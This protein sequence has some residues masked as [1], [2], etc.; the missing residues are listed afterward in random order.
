VNTDQDAPS[1]WYC[2]WHKV[3]ALNL[4]GD[5]QWFIAK[6]K[7]PAKPIPPSVVDKGCDYYEKKQHRA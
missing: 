2:T 6:G 5:C 3:V 7:G 1:C 4:L